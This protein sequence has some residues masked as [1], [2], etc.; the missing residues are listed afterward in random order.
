MIKVGM[1]SRQ[2]QSFLNEAKEKSEDTNKNEGGAELK[3]KGAARRQE[4]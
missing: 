4:R 3:S 2:R 1:E